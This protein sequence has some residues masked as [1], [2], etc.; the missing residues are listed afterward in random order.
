MM[1]K[2]PTLG[3]F[4]LLK[5]IGVGGYSNVYLAHS[6]VYNADCAIKVLQCNN[7]SEEE[8]KISQSLD[9]PFIINVLDSFMSDGQ[10]CILMEYFDG[11][12]ISS[13]I[14]QHGP[15]PEHRARVLFAQMALAVHYLHSYAN[16]SHRD[17]K[18]E[19]ILIDPFGNAKL[20]DFGLAKNETD[21]MSTSCGSPLYLAPEVVQR[22]KYSSK[23][24]IWSLGVVLYS[25]VTGKLPFVSDNIQ[26]LF[27]IIVKKE[28]DYPPNL[29]LE[30]IDLLKGILS[31]DPE[32]RLSIEHVLSHPFILMET[33]S[34]NEKVCRLLRLTNEEKILYYSDNKVQMGPD[35]TSRFLQICVNKDDGLLI[36]QCNSTLNMKRHKIVR[37]SNSGCIKPMIFPYIIPFQDICSNRTVKKRRQI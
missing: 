35:L 8:L 32:E 20:I 1:L 3:D 10:K 30:V 2:H 12:Q 27:S 23:I 26:N 14:Q 16:V 21:L 28:P 24:D 37:P 11:I 13:F 15:L 18:S 17:I 5:M 34:N 22:K 33:M 7:K 36:K 4:K 25:M 9:S 6:M 29:S 19:N 31:K